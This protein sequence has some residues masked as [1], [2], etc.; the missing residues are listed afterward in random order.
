MLWLYMSEFFEDCKTSEL[1]VLINSGLYDTNKYVKYIAYRYNEEICPH[2]DGF[3]HT[4][5]DILALQYS[6]VNL[7]YCKPFK[8]YA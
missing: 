3:S 1:A 4:T 2:N 6:S 7:D 5:L 8:F